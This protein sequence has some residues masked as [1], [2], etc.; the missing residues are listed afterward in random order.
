MQVE[1]LGFWGPELGE[2]FVEVVFVGLKNFMPLR[3]TRGP[4]PSG[5]S[6]RL[7][8]MIKL[9]SVPHRLISSSLYPIVVALFIPPKFGSG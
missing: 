4:E 1:E 3:E 5:V 6:V 8:N 7:K 9:A 2:E